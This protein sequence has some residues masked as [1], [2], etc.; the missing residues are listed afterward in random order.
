MC[1]LRDEGYMVTTVTVTAFD[2]I[3]KFE[4]SEPNNWLFS[5]N[6]CDFYSIRVQ[7]C[8]YLCIFAPAIRKVCKDINAL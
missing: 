3:S 4:L 2:Y 6:L 8:N 5:S 1:A 7:N